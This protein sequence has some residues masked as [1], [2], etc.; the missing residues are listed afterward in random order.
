[1]RGTGKISVPGCV[2]V[3]K[4]LDII[5]R[6]FKRIHPSF[7]KCGFTDDLDIYIDVALELV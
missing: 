1:M 3:L 6:V 4:L 5:W 7:E 2:Q